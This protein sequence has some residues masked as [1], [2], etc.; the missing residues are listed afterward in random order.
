MIDFFGWIV[1][2]IVNIVAYISHLVI[3][4]FRNFVFF[5]FIAAFCWGIFRLGQNG[6]RYF[7][8][9]GAK[10]EHSDITPEDE[11]EKGGG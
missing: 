8:G 11:A 6:V 1:G 7:R 2:S 5:A 4:L 3:V 9:R 10:P